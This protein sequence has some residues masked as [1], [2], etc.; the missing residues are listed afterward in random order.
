LTSFS[1]A[2]TTILPSFSSALKDQSESRPGESS[3][4]PLVTLKQAIKSG[5]ERGGRREGEELTSVPWAD[6]SAVMRKDTLYMVSLADHTLW[7][8]IDVLSRGAPYCSVS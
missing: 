1:L 4:S 3:I 7:D 8:T 5:G 6:Y 2:E